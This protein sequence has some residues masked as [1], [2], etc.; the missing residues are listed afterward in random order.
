MGRAIP[1]G[2]PAWTEDDT[3]LALEYEDWAAE[4]CPGCG[5][6]L[7]ESS[8]ASHEH[9]YEARDRVCFACEAK[10]LRVKA[11]SDTENAVTAGRKIG[12][13]LILDE[14]DEDE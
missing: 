10:E 13:V 3:A 5:H 11:L 9:A 12:A 7:S 14:L 8:D 6:H 1:A 2:E 4:V